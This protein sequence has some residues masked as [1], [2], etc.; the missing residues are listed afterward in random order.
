[1]YI[2]SYIYN[3]KSSDGRDVSGEQMSVIDCI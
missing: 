3:Y 2:Y 1:M